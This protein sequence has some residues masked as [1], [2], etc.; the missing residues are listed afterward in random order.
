M[1]LSKRMEAEKV[2][3]LDVISARIETHFIDSDL[4]LR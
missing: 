1:S 2:A 4:V 3:Y